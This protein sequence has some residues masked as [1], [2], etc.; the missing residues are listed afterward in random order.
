MAGGWMLIVL[1]AAGLSFAPPAA[2][3]RARLTD[4]P[5]ATAHHAVI[6]IDVPLSARRIPSPAAGRLGGGRPRSF[7]RPRIPGG[8]K[9][10]NDYSG[11]SKARFRQKPIAV[12]RRILVGRHVVVGE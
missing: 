5:A 7:N 8:Q 4:S 3:P 1:L 9:R 10:G 2:S 6:R 12:E 11:P